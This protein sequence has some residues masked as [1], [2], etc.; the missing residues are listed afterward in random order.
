M[1]HTTTHFD[2][3]TFW[4]RWKYRKH[5]RNCDWTIIGFSVWWSSPESYCY[6]LCFFGL[7]VKLWL[8]RVFH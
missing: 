3:I 6:K 2:K 1:A 4:N 7:E 8:N 5:T